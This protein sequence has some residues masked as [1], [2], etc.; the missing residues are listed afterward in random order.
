MTLYEADLSGFGYREISMAKD[1][2]EAYLDSNIKPLEGL[3]IGF[4]AESSAVFLTDEDYRSFMMNGDNLEE[5]FN[6]P[7]CGHEGF[8]EE[9]EGQD[10]KECKRIFKE[11]FFSG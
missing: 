3:K 4:N 9:F 10:C 7:E 11:G 2:L 5:W 1:L 8:K 6:C